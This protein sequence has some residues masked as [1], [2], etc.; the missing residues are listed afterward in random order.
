M[1]CPAG[2]RFRFVRLMVP[3]ALIFAIL[4]LHMLG[5]AL[6]S[7]HLLVDDVRGRR[8]K[9]LGLALIWLLPLLGALLVWLRLHRLSGGAQGG[10]FVARG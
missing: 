1:R 9:R 8:E 6:V 10:K 3:L 4:G 5:G 2:P 7:Q